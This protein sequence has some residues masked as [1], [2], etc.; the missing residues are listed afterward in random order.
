MPVA[1][2]VTDIEGT[3]TPISFV[4]RIL[5]P[6]ARRR[7]PGFVREHRNDPAVRDA[8]ADV[9]R[10]ADA[11]NLDEAG[12]IATL[13]GWI[14]EDRKAT[15][16]K[17]LQG[18]IWQEGY[19]AGDF[20]GELYADVGPALRRWHGAGQQLYVYSSGSVAAQ[21][22]LFGHSDQGDLTPVF[23]GYFDTRIG[24]KVEAPSY[25][26]I[27]AEIAAPPGSILFLSDSERELDA[28]IAAGFKVI[29]LARDG[30]VESRYRVVG[31]F[32][33]IV[34]K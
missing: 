18:L 27:A 17:D 25:A 12:V 31:S 21:R 9:R 4:A 34:F 6:H 1:A 14:D 5:F 3:T 20:R 7:L 32:A 8:L 23:S 28:A 22:L 24:S 26:R 30:A 33:E 19:A 11:P 2:V 13:L 15:P 16:L 29:R 10:L